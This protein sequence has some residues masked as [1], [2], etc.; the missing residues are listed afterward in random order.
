MSVFNRLHFAVAKRAT[1]AGIGNAGSKTTFAT[2]PQTIAGAEEHLLAPVFIGAI[3]AVLLAHRLPP[4]V[5]IWLCAAKRC[6]LT[7]GEVR[8]TAV[9]G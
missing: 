7:T 5:A 6:V 4:G 1:R 3:A 2:E 8:A 9:P